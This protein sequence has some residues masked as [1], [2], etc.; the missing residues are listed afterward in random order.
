MLLAHSVQFPRM[1]RR[2]TF[3]ATVLAVAILVVLISASPALAQNSGYPRLGHWWGSATA[4]EN[5][6]LDY[7]APYNSDPLRPDTNAIASLRSANPGVILLTSSS[8]AEVDYSA[9]NEVAYDAQRLAA[10]P[11]SWIL[12]QVGSTLSAGLTASATSVSVVDTSKFRVNDLIIIDNER[13]VVT[14]V[15]TTLTVK[16]GFAG[17]TA[18]A[19]TSGARVAPGVS[20]WNNAVTLDMTANCPLGRATGAFATPGTG[21]ERARDWFARRT[22]GV[23]SAAK[24]DGVLIDVCIADYANTFRGGAGFRTIADRNTPSAEV[25]YTNFDAAWRAGI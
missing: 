11:N 9:T 20:A 16:R 12:T 7:Y 4:T 25:N 1:T 21:T 24:W 23:Y 2:A 8:A 5:T 3:G 13:C 19:H 10:I 22:A 15:G 14:A 17:S 18:A 6:K